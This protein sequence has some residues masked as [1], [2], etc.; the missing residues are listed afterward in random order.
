VVRFVEHG[1]LRRLLP[2]MAVFVI[3]T[4]VLLSFSRGGLAASLAGIGVYLLA[5]KG[6]GVRPTAWILLLMVPVIL[7]SWQA[8]KAP[9]ER[10]IDNAD[11]LATVGGRLPAWE[12]GLKMV[13]DHPVLGTGYGTFQHVFPAYQPPDLGGYWDHVHNDFLEFLIEGGFVTLGLAAA[14]VLV[15]FVPGRSARERGEPVAPF[16]AAAAGGL[17][18]VL[19]HACVDF[20][21][22]IP[23]VA[24]LAALLVG[25]YLASEPAERRDGVWTFPE[26]T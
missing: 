19:L 15:L 22:R 16:R 5:R 12:A 3:L 20:P 18:A 24:L 2:A 17:A 4:G 13:P 8:V 1:F 11:N 14:M 21:L 23:A 7:L 10:F 6:S 25:L 26:R 9:G